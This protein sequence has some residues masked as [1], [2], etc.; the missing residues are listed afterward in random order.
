MRWERVILP[1]PIFRGVKMAEERPRGASS[2]ACM[3]LPG[4]AASSVEI[5]GRTRVIE[6]ILEKQNEAGQGLQRPSI[7]RDGKCGGQK[8]EEKIDQ[9]KSTYFRGRGTPILILIGPI[10]DYWGHFQRQSH[11]A[12]DKFL[13]RGCWTL[14]P[15]QKP[16]CLSKPISSSYH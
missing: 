8:E 2:L 1:F 7:Q 15:S 11:K 4:R 3:P 6:P 14:L 16:H 13:R 10:P 12:Y 5:G 9:G